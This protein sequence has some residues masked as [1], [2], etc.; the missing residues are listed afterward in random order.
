MRHIIAK[1]IVANDFANLHKRDS[2]DLQIVNH[3]I[4]SLVKLNFA[5]SL[6]TN[7]NKCCKPF[8]T[9]MLATMPKTLSSLSDIPSIAPRI[10]DSRN[11]CLWVCVFQKP[12]A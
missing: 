5:M 10:S 8:T 7:I 11:D 1:V 3:N 2:S 9:G 6:L 4:V 12:A